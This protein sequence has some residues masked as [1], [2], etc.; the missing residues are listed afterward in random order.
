MSLSVGFVIVA[1]RA[2]SDDLAESAMGEIETVK[3]SA[4]R[5]A[6]IATAQMAR[7]ARN[8]KDMTGVIEWRD[9][10]QERNVKLLILYW[11]TFI[12]KSQTQQNSS[13]LQPKKYRSAL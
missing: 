13:A 9:R 4:A 1:F 6:A 5:G 2:T 8:L 7:V 10:K 11:P 3:E 12:H